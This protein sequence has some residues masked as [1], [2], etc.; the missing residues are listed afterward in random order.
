MT[1]DLHRGF[2]DPRH[3]PAEELV[4]FLEE[5]DR[6]PDMRVVQKALREALDP[7]PGMR[8]LDAGCGAGLEAA[9]L[10][11]GHRELDVTGVDRNA[12]LLE[13]ARH[14]APQVRWLE[15]DLADLDLPARSFDAIRTERVLMHVPGDTFERVV[16]N[17][18]RMLAP[19]GRLALFE[20][21]YGAM[22]LA[23]GGAEDELVD[24]VAATLYASLP[25]PRAA[26][27]LPELLTAR[28]L[29]RRHR[30]AVPAHPERAGVAAD[31]QRH[32]ACRGHPTP[33]S[34]DGSA[35]RTTPSRAATS[36]RPSRACS[37]SPRGRS[38]SDTD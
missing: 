13:I 24:R 9:R 3:V 18:V 8:L 25:Q 5:A 6:L 21:D 16:D 29:H 38:L 17:L 30:H 7:R 11:E 2:R 28:G 27:R 31:R 33:M 36:S 32:G 20:L 35:S 10:A 1:R 23:P 4:R 14:R 26:R 15:A 22:I 34:R 12:E 37:P 19:G